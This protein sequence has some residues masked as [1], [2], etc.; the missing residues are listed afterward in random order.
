A[1]LEIA[2]NISSNMKDIVDYMGQVGGMLGSVSSAAAAQLET[3]KAMYELAV[4]NNDSMP[5]LP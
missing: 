1:N 3:I 2:T 5:P 4:W